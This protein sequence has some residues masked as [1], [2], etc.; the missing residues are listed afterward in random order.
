MK[1]LVSNKKICI[2]VAFLLNTVAFNAHALGAAGCGLGSI[3]FKD[4]GKVFQILAGTTNG[5]FGSQTFGITS[6]TSNCATSGSNHSNN[7]KQ[8]DYITANL[9]TLQKEAAQGNG[10]SIEGLAA[11]MGC[12]VSSYEEFGAYTQLNYHSIFSTHNAGDVANNI[13]SE[14]Q[15]NETLYKTCNM[16]NI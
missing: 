5:T 13:N 10:E 7:Q 1:Y 16:G 15:K 12:P 11:V 14:L 8:K 3:I 6:G 4:N 9:A 2:S